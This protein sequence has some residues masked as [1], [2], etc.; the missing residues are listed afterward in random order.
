MISLRAKVVFIAAAV[1]IASVLLQQPCWAKERRPLLIPGKHSL[2]QKVLTHPGARLSS[3]PGQDAPQEQ[4]DIKTFSLYYVYAQT[5]VNG[6]QWLEL[7]GGTDGRTNGW[8]RADMCSRWDSA[9]TLEFTERTNRSP[10][11]FFNTYSDLVSLA[12]APSI[13]ARV[14]EL[15]S[16]FEQAQANGEATADLPVK[17]VEPELA[18]PKDL[19]YLMPI[20]NVENPFPGTQFLEVGSVDPGKPAEA[21]PDFRTAVVF[22]IDTSIS[23][24]PY[25]EKTKDVVRTIYDAVEG[26][27]LSDKVA[28]GIVGFRSSTLKTPGLE[29]VSRIYSDMRDATRRN[30]LEAALDSMR[31]AEVSSHA[32]NEDSIQGLM[33]AL[34]GLNWSPY[35]GRVVLLVT[36]AGPLRNDDPYSST[37]L[38]EQEA[39]AQALRRQAYVYALH[40]QTPG[41]KRA[42]NI[43]PAEEAYRTLTARN[44]PALGSLYYPVD[45]MDPVRGPLEF[46][47]VA[48]AIAKETVNWVE[49]ASRGDLDKP[50]DV[51]LPEPVSVVDDPAAKSQHLGY[52][53]LLEYLGARQGAQAPS[54]VR[55]WVS[56]HDLSQLEAGVSNPSF[57][58]SVLLTKLQLSTLQQQLKIVVDEA[59]RTRQTGSKDFFQGILSASAHF[60][61]DPVDF[62]ANPGMN[63][64]ELGVLGEFLD[65]LPYRSDIMRLTEDQWFAKSVG[66]QTA[67]INTLRSKISAYEAY[68]NDVDAWESFNASDPGDFV[69]RVPLSMLP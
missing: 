17:A 41:A 15:Q 26:A 42:G 57:R 31:Q 47:L 32:F 67:F 23:M 2:Y 30:E 56:D 44:D 49:M 38:N 11:L 18:L 6:R 29:Y 64:K 13:P 60:V 10:V 36:D 3:Q 63:L 8:L 5:D 52:A 9:L 68:H 46:A 12:Q 21:A 27:G 51:V 28:F 1:L 20:F 33:T 55:A 66:E 16:R 62:G 50:E 19:F 25:I 24:A 14:K 35:Y 39:A 65:G 69:Y 59:L 40:L 45:A 53:L 22:V 54:V 58:I 34:D 48:E 61:R 7:G 4:P 43:A 37:G